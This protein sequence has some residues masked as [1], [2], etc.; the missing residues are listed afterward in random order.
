MNS[1]RRAIWLICCVAIFGVL[2]PACTLSIS[3]DPT[4]PGTPT[5]P[6]ASTVAPAIFASPSPPPTAAPTAT[7]MPSAAPAST[8]TVAPTATST[9]PAAPTPAPTKTP[10]PSATAVPPAA[11]ATPGGASATW[12][13]IQITLATYDYARAFVKPG[14]EDPAYPYPRLNFALVG[15]LPQPVNYRAI[16]VENKYTALTI[17]PDLGGRLYRWVDK[18]TGRDV[19]YRNPVIKPTQ[20]GYRGWWLAAG[21]MEWAFP[22]EEHGL[23]EYRPWTT[24]VESAGGSVSVIVSD[25]ESRT[26]LDVQVTLTLDGDHNYVSITPR[27]SN[28][29]GRATP[30]QFWL[31]AM[32]APGG[33]NHVSAQTE[34][35]WPPGPVVVH[36]TGDKRMPAEH[37]TFEW[38]RAGAVDLRSYANWR[39]YLGLFESPQSR[40]GYM[41]VY[42]TAS[43]SGV[44]RTFP[45]AIARGAKIFGAP[46]L[47]PTLWTD[48]DSAYLELWGGVTPTFWDSDTLP[49]QGVVSWTE[50][51]YAVHGA[52]VYAMANDNAALSLTVQDGKALVGVATSRL[53]AGQAVLWVAGVAVQR[54]PVM[55][56]PDRP[57]RAQAPVSGG[58]VGLQFLNGDGAVLA[59]TGQVGS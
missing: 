28:P 23:N 52:G 56:G 32:L 43:D 6:G 17:L 31:N 42:D 14:S 2:T 25:T 37:Q 18:T 44:V 58:A 33:R 9:A 39:D 54:W 47:S 48:D 38:P 50:R 35:I 4:E 55:V 57:F 11:T 29:T 26:G 24:R 3:R 16:V 49:P 40:G 10:A 53:F 21:G 15:T 5:A 45:P 8:A 59:Q 27:I 12:R 46:G 7:P 13:E 19:L 41:G 20:W 30:Y 22:V 1:L 51:W 34:I 36:S